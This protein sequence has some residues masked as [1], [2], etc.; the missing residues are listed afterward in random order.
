MVKFKYKKRVKGYTR[1]EHEVA[2]HR[3]KKHLI[4]KHEVKGYT[5]TIT[6]TIKKKK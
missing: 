2:G 5:K 3:V 6:K 4:K 1:G